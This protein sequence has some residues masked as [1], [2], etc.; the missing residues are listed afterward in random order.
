[1]QKNRAGEVVFSPSDLIVYLKSPFASWMDRYCLEGIGDIKPDEATDDQQLIFRTGLEHEK[2]VLA[3]FHAS[4]VDIASIETRDF[5][6]AHRETLAAFAEERGLIYQA[7]LK[8]DRFMGYADFLEFSPS[9]GYIAW[10]TKLARSPKPYYIIQL[11]AYSEMIAL[12]TGKMPDRFGVIL[13]TKERVEFRLEEF[14]HY[15]RQVKANML[16]M[17]DAFTGNLAH[18]PEPNSSADHGRW[19]SY[20]EQYF[21]ETDH[22]VRV[23]GITAGQIK[24]LRRAGLDT[25]TQLAEAAGRTIPKMSGAT[26]DKLAAQARLQCAT[27]NARKDE[28]GN[29]PAF[30][31]LPPQLP[32]GRANGLS[33]LPE[34]HEADVFFDMEGYPLAPGGL[35]YLFG[36]VAREPGSAELRF[37]DWWAHD[38]DQEKVAFE[39]FIDYVYERW[40]ANPDMHIYHYAPYEVSA[41]R[42]LSTRHDTRQEKV[43]DLLRAEKFVD[44]YQTV[45]QSIMIGEDSYS[46]KRVEHLYRCVGR[47]T[48]VATAVDSIVQYANWLS[49]DEPQDPAVSPVLTGIRD[50]NADDCRS[51]AELRDWLLEIGKSK[52]LLGAPLPTSTPVEVKEPSPEVL[53]RLRVASELRRRPDT[54]SKVLGDVLDYHRRE[55][56]P[57]W[58]RLFDRAGA[59]EQ[60]LRDDPG[61]LAGLRAEGGSVP[62]KQSSLQHYSFDPAQECKIAIGD[63]VVFSHNL[64][65]TL[66]V[67]TLDAVTGTIGLKASYRA[68]HERGGFPPGGSLLLHEY[69]PALSIV[70]A[71]T[72]TGTAVLNGE[73]APATVAALIGRSSPSTLPRRSEESEVD[74]AKRIT[75]S[76]DGD[77]FVIQGPPGTGKTYTASRAIAA[78]LLDGKNVGISSNSHKAIIN[79]IHACGHAL[80]EAGGAMKGIKVAGNAEEEIFRRFPELRY[81]EKSADARDEYIGGIVGGTAWLFT[82]PDWVGVLDYL[83]I[84]EAGQVPLANAIAMARSAKNL[85]LLGDQMQLEQPVQGTHPGD[86]GM[87]VLQYA[88]KDEAASRADAPVFHAVIPRDKGLFLGTSRRMHPNVCGFISESIYDGRLAAHEDCARQLIQLEA[89]QLV[90]VESGIQFSGVEHEGNIQRSDEEVERVLAIFEELRGLP[91]TDKTGTTHPLGLK[92]FMFIAPYNAQVRALKDALPPG[93]KVGSVD[94]FQ[95]QEAPVCILSLCSS[96]GEYGSRGLGFILDKNRLNV[97]ISR[98]K[99]LAVVVADPRIAD[100]LP[101]S[102]DEMSLLSLFCKLLQA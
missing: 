99:C 43:D 71:L 39:G 4:G 73:A 16:A 25:M 64:W 7:A 102:I 75:A 51:T 76:M 74:A 35:E 1:M 101:G 69:V 3:E 100:T 23:A 28:P 57:K 34:P 44:L 30:E 54:I 48:D 13:G 63:N 46:I 61:C 94:K 80:E 15:Y 37:K 96:A 91:Y 18:R 12:I 45:R 31:V 93:A 24:R 77:C 20:A 72:E 22:L 97:A 88:L 29:P 36:V 66:A 68:L 17:Q 14:V 89:P 40:Q 32:D 19:T 53:E 2:A 87:S 84:D 41:V 52:G 26:L 83:F 92:D 98:A 81:V 62:V 42:R 86:A 95:G 90:M 55:D 11:C 60:E 59:E 21:E 67:A 49:S 47:G 27:V 5:D 50:Y 38:R 8:N 6:A 56:K 79:L 58:W 10:D 65:M 9:H 85:V 82:R 78:L 33:R 70:R